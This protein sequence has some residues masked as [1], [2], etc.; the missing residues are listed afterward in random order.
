MSFGEVL[1]LDF[2]IKYNRIQDVGEFWVVMWG[3]LSNVLFFCLLEAGI[4]FTPAG[5]S[6][7]WSR[8]ILRAAKLRR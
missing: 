6:F 1:D 2:K 4:F 7:P 8:S 3:Q 5:T